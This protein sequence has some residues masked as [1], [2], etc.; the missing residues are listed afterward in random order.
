MDG[1]SKNRPKK[2]YPPISV[3]FYVCGYSMLRE[4]IINPAVLDFIQLD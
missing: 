4:K 3:T 1:L 2:T